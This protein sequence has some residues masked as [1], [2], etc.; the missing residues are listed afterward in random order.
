MARYTNAVCKLCRREGEKLF[1]K[2]SKCHSDK[3]PFEK[4]SYPPGERGRTRSRETDYLIQLREKQKMKRIYG[5]M[6]RQFK[7]YFKKAL[8]MKG[9]T[10]KN[11]LVLLETRLDNVVYLLGFSSSRPQA[12][13]L[14]NHGHILVNG[15]KV[16]IPS[17]QIKVGQEVEISEKAKKMEPIIQ[18]IAQSSEKEIP[19]WLQVNHKEFK[20]RVISMP[21]R[22]D[23]DQKIKEQLIIELYSR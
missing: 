13:Q 16:S 21:E 10:G 20:G 3:C 19:G 12:R 8:D 4:R 11:L 18:S 23:I 14:V 9:I 17:Y 1:L 5:L 6:E 2:G 15:N 22:K 7:N